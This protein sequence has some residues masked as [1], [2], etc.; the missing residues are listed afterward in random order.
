MIAYKGFTKDLTATRGKGVYKYTIG[1]TVKE[2]KSKTVASGFHCCENPFECL[3]YY[4]LGCG[5]RYLQ[6]EA[7]GSIDEDDCERIACTE[8]TLIKEL[9]LKEFAGYGM[10]YIVQHPMRKKWKQFYNGLQVQEN[11]AVAEEKDHIAIARGKNPKV[12]GKE[13]SL[14]GLILETP[15]GEII[16]AKLL[17]VGEEVKPDTW[18]T[19]NTNRELEEVT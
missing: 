6:V 14:L 11:E 1:E 16:G 2:E 8:L 17:V 7:S 10:M 13:G 3:T 9:T 4:P 18:Y 15:Q 5:N 19:L 12:K